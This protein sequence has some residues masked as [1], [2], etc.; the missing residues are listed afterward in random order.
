MEFEDP[1][2]QLMKT[3]GKDEEGKAKEAMYFEFLGSTLETLLQFENGGNVAKRIEMIIGFLHRSVMTHV[4]MDMREKALYGL[5]SI[6]PKHF[7]GKHFNSNTLKTL[8]KFVLDCAGV[9]ASP[10][11]TK[12]LPE[13]VE[14]MGHVLHEITGQNLGADAKEWN[15]WLRKE[16]K[17]LF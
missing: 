4:N 3:P 14:T 17:E 1:L 7:E 8:K 5:F 6:E 16:G 9:M 11:L 2:V 12:N 15:A 10:E 13:L